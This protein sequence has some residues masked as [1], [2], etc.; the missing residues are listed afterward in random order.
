MGALYF[1][2][3]WRGA[4]KQIKEGEQETSRRMVT[5][6]TEVA[7]QAAG[8][9]MPRMKPVGNAVFDAALPA[10]NALSQDLFG[11][12]NRMEDE[13][14]ALNREDVFSESALAKESAIASEIRKRLESQNIIERYKKGLPPMIESARTKFTSLRASDDV[15][16]GAVRGFDKAASAQ[17]PKLDEMFLL[18]L[19]R[20]KAEA[21]FLRFMLAAFSDYRFAEK[22]ISFKTPA[23]SQRY[24]GLAQGIQDAIKDAEAFQQRQLRA[25]E[26]LKTQVEKLAP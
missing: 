5:N 1:G 13:I 12:L 2:Y 11:Y 17:V 14:D 10:M 16:R 3:V 7:E 8:G 4:E 6:L 24:K 22:V 26:A 18:R 9:S 21:D 20:E 25:V 15:K 23:N 19:R